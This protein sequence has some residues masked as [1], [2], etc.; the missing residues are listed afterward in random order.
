MLCQAAEDVSCK[1]LFS[2]GKVMSYAAVLWLLRWADVQ[3]CQQ[4]QADWYFT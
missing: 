3:A 2:A 4:S 1:S